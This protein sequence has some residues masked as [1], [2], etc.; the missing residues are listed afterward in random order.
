M[1]RYYEPC[2]VR[3]RNALGFRG[4]FFIWWQTW[5]GAVIQRLHNAHYPSFFFLL[6]QIDSVLSWSLSFAAVQQKEKQQ[7][8]KVDFNQG[9]LSLVP[10]FLGVHNLLMMIMWR[11]KTKEDP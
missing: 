3:S 4:G 1:D 7:C 5:A 11:A 9:S 6:W 10:S 2:A 8:N